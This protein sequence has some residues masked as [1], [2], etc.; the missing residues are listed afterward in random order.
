MHVVA[1]GQALLDPAV[2]R[3]VIE[4]FA[5]P[6]A[7]PDPLRVLTAREREIVEQVAAGLTNDEIAA[8]LQL[9]VWTVKTHVGAILR[10]LGAR[11]RTHIVIAAYR[12]RPR[13]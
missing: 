4:R 12:S 9:S 3:R 8:A 6:E 10:K 2:T 1:G 11:D 5:R 13:S 7:G